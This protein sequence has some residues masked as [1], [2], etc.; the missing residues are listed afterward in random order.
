MT[1]Q[2]KK[3]NGWFQGVNNIAPDDSMPTDQYKKV[4]ALRDGVNVDVLTSGKVRRRRGIRQV[5]ADPNAHSIFS[6]G[7]RLIWATLTTLKTAILGQA[8]VTLLSSGMLAS[9]LSYVVVNGRTYFSNEKINGIINVD[10]TYE[11]WGIVPPA[12]APTL[13]GVAGTRQYQ[14][15]CTF[16]T[17][18][19]EES[20]APIGTSIS[21]DDAANI[22]VANIPQSS[23][24]RVVA[25]RLYATNIDGNQ[26]Y[27]EVD[28]PAGITMTILHGFTA[29][30][31]LLKTQF[32]VPP[33]P[34]QLLEYNN[35]RIYIASGN[36]VF[37]TQAL[38][39][40]VHNP[41]T[42]FFMHSQRVTALK[43]VPDGIYLSSDQIYYMANIG[44]DEV[45]QVQ[46]IPGTAFEGMTCTLPNSEDIMMFT[47]RG[48]VRATLGGQTKTLTESQ[49]AV[50]FVT[51]G[52][53][54]YVE[55]NGH[56]S[57]VALI[58]GS[59][60]NP[61]VSDDFRAGD[62]QRKIDSL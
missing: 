61:A 22:L 11:P 60:A 52:A 4:V 29:N 32:M 45:A 12:A 6:E 38:R 43:A 40:G 19:G 47:N 56:K 7:L 13:T 21:T 25:T 24:S 27:H 53:L 36:N 17:A 3:M 44:T 28:I 20:G 18:S 26:F 1:V 54:G 34:G 2:T 57:I 46:T 41:V 23:D 8:S 48:L 37:Y 51:R 31:A 9:P 5:I 16:V 30:G 39:Y 35:G 33:P 50:D 15:T 59:T 49:I 14:V 62:S 58:A 10:G 55:H 42:N